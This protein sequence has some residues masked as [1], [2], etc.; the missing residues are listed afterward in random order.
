R[1]DIYGRFFGLC[2]S[3][4]HSRLFSRCW[5]R[6]AVPTGRLVRAI[7]QTILATAEPTIRT[8]VDRPVL[9]YRH[10]RLAGVEQ[11]WLCWRYSGVRNLRATTRPECHLDADLLW[12]A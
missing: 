4:F 8:G 9:H 5:H 7:G 10:F 12:P 1:K 2:A 11:S 6:R 3:W